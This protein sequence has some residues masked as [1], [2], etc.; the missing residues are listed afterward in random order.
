MK[1]ALS[2][3]A[4][5]LVLLSATRSAQAVRIQDITRLKGDQPNE[6][7]GMGMVFGLKGTGDGG[8]S[9]YAMRALQALLGKFGNPV[10]MA[11]EL[12]NANNV[13]L[14]NISVTVPANGTLTG[15]RLDVRVSGIACKNLKGGQLFVAPMLGPHPADRTIYALSS[16][17]LQ[18]DEESP[19]VGTIKG[20][21]VMQ[22]D[23]RMEPVVDGGFTLVLLPASA[24][25]A[26]ATAIAAQIN[27][28]ASPQTD[29]RPIAI[30]DDATS[31][32]VIIPKPEQT[33]PAAFIARIKALPVPSLP[34]AAKVRINAHTGTIV[35][36]GDVE[37]AP[38]MICHKG[39]TINIAPPDAPTSGNGAGGTANLIALDPAKQ[40]GATLKE[41]V[42]AFNMLKVGPEDR[43]EIVKQLVD[44][45]ALHCELTAE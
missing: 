7:V 21:C 13:A 35:F 41:L 2:I 39:L 29:G 31:I 22:T 30:A 1:T 33:H 32:R 23:I 28:D 19:N 8:K 14:V 3:V 44:I 20:G 40:G 36:S 10:I 25:Y 6:L 5:L 17:T 42:N 9:I 27:E 43:I 15:D 34:G 37:L 38:A 16:G 11:K 26:M 12:E 45:G 24:S 18:T 4:A